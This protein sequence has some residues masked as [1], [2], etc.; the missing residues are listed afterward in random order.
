MLGTIEARGA[1]A[2]LIAAL[3]DPDMNVK[4][5][6]AEELGKIGHPQAAR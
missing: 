1:V 6:A 2:S 5:A 3:A 4:H